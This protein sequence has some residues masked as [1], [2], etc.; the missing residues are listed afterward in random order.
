MC[1]IKFQ[2]PLLPIF[3]YSLPT[4]N[5]NISSFGSIQTPSSSL[6]SLFRLVPPH[7]DEFYTFLSYYKF[8]SLPFSPL[9]L[10]HSLSF[11][12]ITS[13]PNSMFVH[14]QAFTHVIYHIVQGEKYGTREKGRLD[15]QYYYYSIQFQYHIIIL[16]TTIIL[17]F[18]L[19]INYVPK[20]RWVWNFEHSRK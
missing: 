8:R 9:V 12:P 5:L 11:P 19:G 1:I 15:F 14:V 4:V 6:L 17:P 18:Y 20:A 7:S 16:R 13:Y 2:H 10:C 3:F